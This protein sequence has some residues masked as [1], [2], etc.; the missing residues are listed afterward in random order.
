MTGV[1]AHNVNNNCATS[2]SAL[3]LG[4]N[5]VAGG[6]YDCVH[7]FGDEKMQVGSISNQFSDRN[8]PL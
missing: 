1:P 3:H 5:L 7:C 2:S 8:D 6:V 4:K